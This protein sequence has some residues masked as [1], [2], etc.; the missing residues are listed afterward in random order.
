MH[1]PLST[2][3]ALA[4]AIYG[5]AAADTY[6]KTVGG[7]DTYYVGWTMNG[8]PPESY[9]TT[10]NSYNISGSGRYGEGT[11]NGIAIKNDSTLSFGF[12]ADP[13]ESWTVGGTSNLTG[14]LM[15]S[16]SENP[17]PG[18][19]WAKNGTLLFDHPDFYGWVHCPGAMG[20]YEDDSGPLYWAQAPIRNLTGGCTEVDLVKYVLN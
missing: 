11:F 4:A 6:L 10:F 12:S 14:W 16:E 3:F 13:A 7:N 20:M 17:T 5:S 9:F 2:V 18:F 19:S 8:E 1:I 15:S